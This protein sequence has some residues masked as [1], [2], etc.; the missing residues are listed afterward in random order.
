[1]QA[2]E[3]LYNALDAEFGLLTPA[4]VGRAMGSRSR[5]PRNYA[6]AARAAGRLLA[7]DRNSQALYPGFQFDDNGRPLEVIAKLRALGA[8]FDRTETGIVQWLLSPTTYLADARPVDYLASDA[9]RVLGVAREA[10][11]VQW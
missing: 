11:G 6:N 2:Q 4:A 3:N 9:D 8:E 5:A 10:S 7:L 1:L